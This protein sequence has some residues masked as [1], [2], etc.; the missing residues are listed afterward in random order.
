MG[1]KAPILRKAPGNTEMFSAEVSRAGNISAPAKRP[2]LEKGAACPRLI[3]G[4][5]NAGE[6]AP[7]PA[8]KMK[9][10]GK[11]ARTVMSPFV[12]PWLEKSENSRLL[13]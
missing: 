7:A 6:H 2:A 13:R 4:T 12:N 9:N 8:K 5:E 3:F 10:A 1:S 11:N